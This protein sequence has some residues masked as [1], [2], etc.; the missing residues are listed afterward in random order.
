MSRPFQLRP[1]TI[2][3]LIDYCRYR[4]VT[5]LSININSNYP[6]K[7]WQRLSSYYN[8]F[9]NWSGIELGLSGH[10]ASETSLE[11]LN[12][13]YLVLSNNWYCPDKYDFGDLTS[14]NCPEDRFQRLSINWNCLNNWCCV[15][16]NN[17]NRPNKWFWRLP[18]IWKSLN[19]W[20]LV[21]S[22]SWSCSDKWSRSA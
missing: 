7:R 13:W 20:C 4:R 15:L 19:N 22:Q 2:D 12:K 11:C 8:C 10:L 18:N 21:L 14:L 1:R 5:K 9:D 3:L 6:G 17:R 16:L